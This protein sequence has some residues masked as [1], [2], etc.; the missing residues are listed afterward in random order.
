MRQFLSG[1]PVLSTSLTLTLI[2]PLLIG[3]MFVRSAC[4]DDDEQPPTPAGLTALVQVQPLARETLVPTIRA[5]GQAIADPTRTLSVTTQTGGQVTQLMVEAG[6]WVHKGQKLLVLTLDPKAR[7][8]YQKAQTQLNVAE[9]DLHQKQYLFARQMATKQEV[10]LARQA[11][12]DARKTLMAQRKLGAGEAVH[13]IRASEDALILTMPV[14]VGALVPPGGVLATMSA[15]HAL[16]LRLGIEPEDAP[17]VAAGMTVTFAPVFTRVVDHHPQR[18]AKVVRVDGRINPATRLL[19]VV[20]RPD[21]SS[22]TEVASGDLIAGMT[23][24]ARIGLPSRTGLVVPTD[25][26]LAIGKAQPHVFVI[27]AGHAASVSVR[28]ELRVGD[29]T[30]VAPVTPGSLR[31]GDAIVVAGQYALK[32]DMAVR[33][34]SDASSNGIPQ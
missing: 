32:S 3:L 8:A 22:G 15:R 7:L 14:S 21:G 23:V 11:V 26:V 6:Q 34:A 31:V 16:L 9:Q 1:Q 33:I 30:L 13:V 20:A 25:A 28:P 2:A 18:T 24:M 5:Y 17:R 10:V 19:D 4:A 29:R 27:R 12:T